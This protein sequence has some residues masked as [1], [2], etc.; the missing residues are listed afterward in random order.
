MATKNRTPTAGWHIPAAVGAW[1]LPG[2]GHFIL[3]E[4]TRGIILS[5]SIGC[6]WIG[7]LSIGGITVCDSVEHP[8]WFWAQML[9][10][11]SWAVDHWLQSLREAELVYA[12][13]YEPSFG[14]VSEQGI[15]YTALAGLLNLLAII[16]VIYRDP[17][18]HQPDDTDTAHHHPH[19]RP[20]QRDTD[21]PKHDPE[22]AAT[23]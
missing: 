17:R 7:G 2:L 19:P 5:L 23:E 16:D 18:H 12:S 4:K 20:F 10:A 22:P 8:Y 14:R 13:L 1:L 3:G 6:L 21:T 15:L 9:M 11:P